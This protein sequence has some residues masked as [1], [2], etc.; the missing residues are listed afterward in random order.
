M[1]LLVILPRNKNSVGWPPISRTTSRISISHHRNVN[2]H[3]GLVFFLLSPNSCITI[4][5]SPRMTLF[6]YLCPKSQ[7]SWMNSSGSKAVVILHTAFAH[8]AAA[9]SQKYVVWIV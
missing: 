1:T 7:H 2:A 6:D 4:I 5:I 9:M 3:L 8:G